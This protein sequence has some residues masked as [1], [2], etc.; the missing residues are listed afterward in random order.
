MNPIKRHFFI[1]ANE[2]PPGAKPSCGNKNGYAIYL[3]FIEELQKRNLF[4]EIAVTVSGC[5]GP[6]YEGV[7]IVV[8]PEGTWYINVTEKDVNEIA[9]K[10]MAKGIIVERLALNWDEE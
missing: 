6:C 4:S 2:H 7:V 5:L 9:E 3:K 8:Y 10:H 1:C